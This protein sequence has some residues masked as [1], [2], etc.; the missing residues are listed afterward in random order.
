M[1]RSARKLF[2]GLAAATVMAAVVV[3]P[4]AAQSPAPAGSGMA[5]AYKIGVRNLPKGQSAL[6]YTREQLDRLSLEK[7]LQEIYWGSKLR[8]LPPSKLLIEKE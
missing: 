6:A 4:V 1:D 5:H 3:G 8:K 2:T 7:D